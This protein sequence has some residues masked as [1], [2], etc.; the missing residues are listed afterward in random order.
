MS[1][2]AIALATLLAV[3]ASFAAL[4]LVVASFGYFTR[5][6]EHSN[7]AK[8]ASDLLT[9][10]SNGNVRAFTDRALEEMRAIH[11]DIMTKRSA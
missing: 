3:G 4:F 10:Q 5:R 2:R 7:R 1:D 6:V 8:I 11:K 9:R